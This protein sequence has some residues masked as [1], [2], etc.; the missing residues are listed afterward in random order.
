MTIFQTSEEVRDHFNEN[1]GASYYFDYPFPS[2]T[3]FPPAKVWK[4]YCAKVLCCCRK[5]KKMMNPSRSSTI[6]EAASDDDESNRS[7]SC[8]NSEGSGEKRNLETFNRN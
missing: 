5:R 7:D 3:L 8:T 4:H 2:M 6:R 1:P